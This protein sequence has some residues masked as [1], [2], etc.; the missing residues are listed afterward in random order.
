MGWDCLAHKSYWLRDHFLLVARSD[1]TTGSRNIKL[2]VVFKV[3]KMTRSASFCLI[4]GPFKGEVPVFARLWPIR[5]RCYDW[6]STVGCPSNS[7]AF[8]SK[9]RVW[10]K[11]L[12]ESTLIFGDTQIPNFLKQY[13][14]GSLYAKTGSITAAVLIQQWFVR[15]R[16]K[17]AHS[18]YQ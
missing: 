8:C 6:G 5:V 11:L 12:E 9:S 4:M 17:K 7:W 3:Q 18:Q 14:V 2:E 13:S 10:D 1:H 16:H 15:H